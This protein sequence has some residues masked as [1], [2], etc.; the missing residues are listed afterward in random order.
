MK[1]KILAS[2]TQSESSH[3]MKAIF[4]GL[5]ALVY[6]IAFLALWA[7]MALSLLSLDR[8]FA[9]PLP[10]WTKFPG[11]ALIIIGGILAL[12]CVGTFVVR[13]KGTPAPFD[14]PREFVA[15]GPYRYVRNPMYIGG[16]LMLSGLG[17]YEHSISILLFSLVGLVLAHLFIL[18]IEE[19]GLEKRF[20]D[21]Y[22]AYNKSINR[23][24]PRR[25]TTSS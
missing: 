6:M 24:I 18:L 12:S 14:A 25:K 16:W 23:W 4:I 11:I 8:L 20:G 2:N 13:G 5:R 17:L 3:S 21:S 15:V 10:F 19:P 7:W 1:L 9:I 22:R